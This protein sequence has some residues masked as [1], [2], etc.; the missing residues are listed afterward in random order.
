M[1]PDDE[2]EDWESL[3]DLPPSLGAAP[4]FALAGIGLSKLLRRRQ[5]GPRKWDSVKLVHAD[6]L[7]SWSVFPRCQEFDTPTYG[8]YRAGREALRKVGKRVAPLLRAR[9]EL[10][11]LDSGEVITY[12]TEYV[13]LP[14][15]LLRRPRRVRL[16]HQRLPGTWLESD[17][18]TVSMSSSGDA[19]VAQPGWRR[20][21]VAV[22]SVGPSRVVHKQEIDRL[23]EELEAASEEQRNAIAEV[24]T[25]RFGHPVL[26]VSHRWESQE[27]PDPTGHQLERL[28]AL[29]DCWIIYDYTSFPQLPRTEAEEAQFRQILDSM[30]ELIKKVVILASPDHLTRGWLVFEYLVASLGADI[31]CDEVNAPNFIDLRN[32]TATE[33]PL[34][35]N[36]WR[37]SWESPQSNYINQ[38]VL[39]AVNRVLPIYS[40]ARFRTE[41]DSTKVTELLAERLKAQLP[42]RKEHQMYLGEWK[43]IQ[44]TQEDLAEA[45]RGEIDIPS[46]QTMKVKP[47]QTQVPTTLEEAV[48]RRYKLKKVTWKERTNPFGLLG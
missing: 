26:F 2:D 23:T 8:D 47:F 37:D 28:R 21:S 45:F 16:E 39:S 44:W 34:P 40:N 3:L 42:A 25:S 33:A 32:W 30:T 31:V 41:H 12:H 17:D 9:R 14:R 20:E 24:E 13:R 7:Q 48:A 1:F 27:H 11:A 43:Y 6:D 18:G 22:R 5:G 38:M 46:D 19:V 10:A 35:T 4:L 36:P 29:K 15:S